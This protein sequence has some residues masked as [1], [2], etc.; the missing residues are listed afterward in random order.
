MGHGAEGL[1]REAVDLGRVARV[2]GRMAGV[3][4][5]QAGNIERRAE[6]QESAMRNRTI[7]SG[8]KSTLTIPT[9]KKWS[10]TALDV[11]GEMVRREDGFAG[12]EEDGSLGEGD[13]SLSA[14]L[15]LGRGVSLCE[16]A[17]PMLVVGVYA[18]QGTKKNWF[19]T[20]V[21]I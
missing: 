12:E 15:R 19:W 2:H 3:H 9:L 7:V 20:S 6:E 10:I 21:Q 13:G 16:M 17:F 18:D 11:D 1:G 4:G 14:R 8:R 5:H